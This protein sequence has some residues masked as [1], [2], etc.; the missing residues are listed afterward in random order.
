MKNTRTTLFHSIIS[1][2]LCV[3]MLVGTTFAWFTDSVTTGLN[4]I[5]AGVLDV[6]VYHSNAAVTNERVE[7]ATELFK[8]LD[9][10]DI[11]W[12]PG[13]VSYENLRV[14]NAGDLALVYRMTMATANENF[15][16]GIYGLS[17]ALQVGVVPGGVTAT[18]RQGVIA[19]VEGGWTTLSEFLRS[20]TLL[21][22]GESEQTWGVVV[23]WEPGEND[24]R[25]NLNNDKTLN[26]GEV[27]TIDLGISLIATQEQ[28]EI[29][30]FG[31]DYDLNAKPE[32]FP[33][34]QGGEITT[35]VEPD[36]DGLIAAEV[37]MAVGH[38]AAVVP[39]GVKLADGASQLTL[40]VNEMSN[41]GTNI[42]L[43]EDEAMRSLDVHIDGV[44][45]DNDQPITVTLKNAVTPGLNSTSIALYH[46]ENGVTNPM[47]A[48][49]LDEL[50]AHNEYY[51]DAATGTVILSM[52]S[53]SEVAV[54][55]NESNPW[56]GTPATSFAGGS[57]TE[58]EPYTIANAEQLAYFR[59]QVDAGNTYAGRFVKLTDNIDLCGV[60][61]DPIGW[62][63]DY[64]DHNRDDVPGKTFKG[65]FDGGNYYIYN[66]Y[67]N[68]WDLEEATKTDYT[69]TN[70]G[71]GLFASAT[72]AIIK[73][74]RISGAEI[75]V[76]CVEAGIV[77]GLAQGNCEFENIK[78]F[79][80][81]IANYQRPAGGLIGE[82]SAAGTTNITN[83]TI[84]PDVV[85]GSMWG[86]FDT[87]VGGVIGARWADNDSDP[88]VVMDTV[89]VACRLDVY[90]DVTST[91][92]WYAYRRAGML[93]GNTDT[94]A[95][96]GKNAQTATAGFLT[97]KD[98]KVYYGDWVNYHYCEFSNA[99]S[100]WPWVRVE[101]GENCSA[102]SNPRWGVATNTAGEKVTPENHSKQA[103][104]FHVGGDEC[105]VELTFNQLYGGGQGVYGQAEHSGVT[106]SSDYDYI[107]Y[108]MD[109]EHVFYSDYGTT[110]T[111]YTVGNE[112]LIGHPIRND[113]PASVTWKTWVNAASVA[114][115]SIP[116]DNTNDQ[117]VYDSWNGIYTARFIHHTG[118]IM[119]DVEFT[120]ETAGNVTAPTVGK[121]NI[122]GLDQP[123]VPSW[124][125][126]DGDTWKTDWESM[127][128][129]AT[130]D[131]TITLAYTYNGQL[132]LVPVDDSPKDGIIESYKVT[133]TNEITMETV[134]IPGEIDGVL[135]TT[136]ERIHNPDGGK[137][138]NNWNY[139]IKT[140][141]VSEGV[142]R[143]NDNS[144]AYTPD[145][146]TVYLP[147]S[148]TYIGKNAFSRNLATTGLLIEND[149]KKLTI[150]FNGSRTE[151]DAIG[152][153]KDWNNGLKS[154]S[155]V[156]FSDGTKLDV[157]D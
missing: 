67:Q 44:A 89:T 121:L 102:F 149:K 134:V 23:Y 47:T 24:D 84:G 65:T 1:L 74:L 27:L 69:Y 118:R 137:N 155:T 144:L 64:K 7:S 151:W 11:L 150:H 15:V 95:A 154:G 87:P 106:V 43:G 32:L 3:S 9:G 130:S 18:D 36:E 71:F 136:I 86:D 17:E 55:A 56:T 63:Y 100:S 82:V 51:Y 135:V 75:V 68:G 113:L 103:Y 131:K 29:D 139:A 90:N 39:E 117:Y 94:P 48:V 122:D 152:K 143:I 128:A 112:N 129:S 126:Y 16:E 72:D 33:G 97:C 60:N 109:R 26:E 10:D 34:F 35:S 19:S 66:L 147:S 79:D 78:I 41:T 93:I 116:A 110:G 124:G 108:Y 31:K 28:F 58:A 21:P 120:K 40:N 132:G 50:D 101:A 157:S 81:K 119:K 114:V 111:Q 12:E 96:D 146:G 37:S 73:N 8:D 59:D 42:Q 92:Q 57:G 62:G 91:Y 138:W 52:A 105:Y 85:I 156:I 115:T 107:V 83:V 142:E 4:T 20:G 54:V 70:C 13:V 80:S 2:L 153:H 14:V 38:V 30:S 104:S 5:A 123:L 46:V 148:L 140:I 49:A 45:A 88:L 76:E 145:L 141:K 99:N 61:F 25:W 6:E 127:L 53:F 98:V 133:P 22:E 125:Y 77:V